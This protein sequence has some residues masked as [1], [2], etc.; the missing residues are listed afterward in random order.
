V[1][2]LLAA[3]PSQP[4]EHQHKLDLAAGLARLFAAG[5]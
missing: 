5:S 4:S 3:D 2:Q 1:R